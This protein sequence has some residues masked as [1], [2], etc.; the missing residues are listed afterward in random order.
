MGPHDC[1]HRVTTA[2][3][4]QTA[5]GST[6][7]PALRSKRREKAFTLVELLVVTCIIAL[8]L[9]MLMPALGRAKEA[10][11]LIRCTAN[12]RQLGIAVMLYYHD[13]NDEFP[14]S[15]DYTAS[16]S[17][18]ERIWPVR[19]Q[20][21]AP[22]QQLVL[23]PSAHNSSF[24]SNWSM[25]GLGS[26]GYTTAT[27]YDPTHQEGF[28]TSTKTTCMKSPV[29]TPLFTDTPCGPTSE[30]YRGYVFDPYNGEPNPLDPQMGTPL[31]A[32]RDLVPGLAAL[33]PALMKPVYARHRAAG[34]N[35]GRS[36]LILADGHAQAYTAASVLAQDR[37]ARLFWRFRPAP[38]MSQ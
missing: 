21:Y 30:K 14:P 38:G 11:R 35:S 27:A 9:A 24:P 20:A 26:I 2:K 37:G 13:Q 6:M 36:M 25:R 22:A 18:P 15:T 4:A 3:R 16:T 17:L 34:D 28:P 31:I 5:P 1:K 12:G 29:N 10:A 32:D 8:L 33:P 19:I 23:C 7:R